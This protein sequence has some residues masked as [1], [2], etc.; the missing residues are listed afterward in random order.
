MKDVGLWD[1]ST[2]HNFAWFDF[3]TWKFWTKEWTMGKVKIELNTV[4]EYKWFANLP[5]IV[6]NPRNKCCVY[7]YRAVPRRSTIEFIPSI[8][9]AASL[10]LNAQWENTNWLTISLPNHPP[11]RVPSPRAPPPPFS[12]HCV[13]SLA[14]SRGT[15]Q[16]IYKLWIAVDCSDWIRAG[17][18]VMI[19]YVFRGGGVA[20]RG[21]EGRGKGSNVLICFVYKLLRA[22][23]QHNTHLNLPPTLISRISMTHHPVKWTMYVKPLYS[24]IK[25]QIYSP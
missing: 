23:K 13:K 24:S 19:V 15:H 17:L 20:P 12:S 4:C 21:I 10:T 14:P 11:P 25:T 8:F 9:H 2:I 5:H 16:D 7:F 22:T 6:H 3:S 18:Q 1:E